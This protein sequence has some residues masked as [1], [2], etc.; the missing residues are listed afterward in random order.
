MHQNMQ[1]GYLDKE[2]HLLERHPVTAKVA[3]SNPSPATI[4]KNML[5]L[6]V[7]FAL[8]TRCIFL[9]DIY[10]IYIVSSGN[11]TYTMST[12]FLD[13]QDRTVPAIFPIWA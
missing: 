3:G 13:Y 5:F 7:L 12:G 9:S 1:T 10:K 8:T 2:K 4:K 6:H 11:V